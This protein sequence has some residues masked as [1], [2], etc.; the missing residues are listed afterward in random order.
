MSSSRS[1][2][3]LKVVKLNAA[4]F[5]SPS[6]LYLKLNTETLKNITTLLDSGSTDCF[7][8]SRFAINN[9]LPLENLKKPLRLS[10]FDGSTASQ[11]LILQS[12][13]L[14][15]SF[16]CGTRHRVRFLL[17]PLDPSASAVLGYSWLIQANPS[18]NWITQE[19]NFR[20]PENENPSVDASGSTSERAPPE[21]S[22][23]TPPP[24]AAVP[25]PDL[26]ES[27]PE[28][29]AALRA[30]AAKISVSIINSHAVNLLTRLPRSHP[31][32][33][34]C[35]GIIRPSSLLARAADVT[36]APASP[37]PA[38]VA[39]L[40]A[41]R[42][43]V[44][45]H[46]QQRVYAFSKQKGTTLPPRHSYDHSIE[47]EAGTTPP[48]GPIYSLSEVEQLALREFLNENLANHFIR[49]SQSSAGAPILFIRKKDG[50]LRLAV[51]YRGLNRI[52]KKDRY[53]LPLIPDLLDRL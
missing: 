49:P 20:T 33:I 3:P 42:P 7:I 24:A 11:G 38:L 27:S 36:S 32:S 47:T 12:T 1:S 53:P 15:V 41:L 17:T 30:A 52:T 16:P 34:V 35:S 25:V 29:S 48:Y 40:N 23:E 22:P 28:P 9:Q 39:E 5:Y 8:D 18:I 37:D 43:L 50:S 19:I 10:L 26:H 13:T 6:A 45:E 51:D 14:D 44:P 4:S 31:S 21:L 2:A 46:Y